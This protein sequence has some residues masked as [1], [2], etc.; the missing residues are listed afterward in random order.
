[1]GPSL[2]VSLSIITGRVNLLE[3][4][5]SVSSIVLLKSIIENPNNLFFI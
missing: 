1:M 4:F 3:V 2:S 5:V